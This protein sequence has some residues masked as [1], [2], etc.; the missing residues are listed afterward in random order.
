MTNRFLVRLVLLLSIVFF[1][2]YAAAENERNR[3]PGFAGIPAGAKIAVLPS[4]I[5][6]FSISAG[7]VLEP[8]AD[9]TAAAQ[10]HL[11]AAVVLKKQQWGLEST[12][13][14]ETDAEE[15][16]DLVAL[17]AAIARSISLHYWRGGRFAL[18]TKNGQL[19]WSLGEESV[20]RLREKT[21]AD[22]GLFIWLRDSYASAERKA[23]MVGLALL[24][25]G[26]GG[27]VQ[28]GYATLVDLK[29]GQVMW[30]NQIT[31]TLGDV[32]EE[33]PA[34][35]TVENLLSYFPLRNPATR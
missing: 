22:Y 7:G 6:L 3:A 19:D 33:R 18:P 11:T 20:Q 1:A 32:R 34:Q 25:I 2:G 13:V 4:D 29:T 31:S 16:T 17:Q 26:I 12:L 15:F 35:Q 5:E 23:M 10:K 14:S 27:G 9:W 30:F 8:K 21:R 28:N 24:G